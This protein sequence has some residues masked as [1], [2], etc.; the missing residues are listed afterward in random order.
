M[1]N[2]NGVGWISRDGK[3]RVAEARYEIRVVYDA[4]PMSSHASNLRTRLRG[5][6]NVEIAKV[7]VEAE[8]ARDG[9]FVLHMPKQSSMAKF[10]FTYGSNVD[11]FDGIQSVPSGPA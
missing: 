6:G 10:R 2:Y 3:T 11:L 9:D 4:K 5:M 7:Y 1:D 8:V